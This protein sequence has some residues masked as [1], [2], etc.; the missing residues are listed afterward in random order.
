MEKLADERK[1]QEYLTAFSEI[2]ENL[3]PYCDQGFEE[4]RHHKSLADCLRDKTVTPHAVSQALFAGELAAEN[5]SL[6]AIQRKVDCQLSDW[7]EPSHSSA[8]YRLYQKSRLWQ[9][10]AADSSNDN[11]RPPEGDFESKTKHF[12]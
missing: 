12:S 4:Q 8:T 6:A 9:P 10:P 1:A 2:F 7:L 5:L 3:F 11:S